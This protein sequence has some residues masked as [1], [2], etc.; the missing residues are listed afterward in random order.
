MAIKDHLS[1]DHKKLWQRHFNIALRGTADARMA[2]SIANER[3]CRDI[4]AETA[5][6]ANAR[7]DIAENVCRDE[8]PRTKK[9]KLKV[10][11]DGWIG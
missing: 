1:I 7:N 9:D 8:P 6:V 2:E 4:N 5:R 3:T 10:I 11:Q